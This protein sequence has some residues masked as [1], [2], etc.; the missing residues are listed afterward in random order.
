[1]YCIVKFWMQTIRHFTIVC[2]YIIPKYHFHIIQNK[3]KRLRIGD[4]VADHEILCPISWG[5]IQYCY[6][7]HSQFL[8]DIEKGK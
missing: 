8:N 1:M 7:L 3:T 2:H 5:N 4:F 6:D